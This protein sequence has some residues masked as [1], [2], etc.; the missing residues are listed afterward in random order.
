MK[1]CKNGSQNQGMSAKD[2]LK[3]LKVDYPEITKKDVNSNLYKLLGKKAVKKDTSAC[4]I[5]TMI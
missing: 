1:I 3:K 4:P 5:W 2:I